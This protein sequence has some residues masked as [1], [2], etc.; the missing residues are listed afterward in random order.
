MLRDGAL[1][2]PRNI[3][4]SKETGQGVTSVYEQEHVQ[5]V[6]TEELD[7]TEGIVIVLLFIILYC[8]FSAVS[9]QLHNLAMSNNVEG[10]RQ[11]V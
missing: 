2:T 8:T 10:I 7:I 5:N 4:T 11:E 1:V 3:L 9:S 6:L